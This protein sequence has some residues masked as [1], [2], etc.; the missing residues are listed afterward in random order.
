M[1][2]APG[3]EIGNRIVGPVDFLLIDLGKR[4]GVAVGVDV[5]ILGTIAK[6]EGEANDR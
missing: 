6:G 1:G 2:R 3:Q 4:V 5:G